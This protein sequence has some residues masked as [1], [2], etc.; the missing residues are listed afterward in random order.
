MQQG[1]TFSE[2]RILGHFMSKFL[3]NL[4]KFVLDHQQAKCFSK[5]TTFGGYSET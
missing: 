5:V 4:T 1:R 2:V 3:Q